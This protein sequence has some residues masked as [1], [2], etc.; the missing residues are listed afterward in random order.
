MNERR[1][2]VQLINYWKN[3]KIDSPLPVIESMDSHLLSNYWFNSMVLFS[4]KD[5]PNNNFHIEYIG[6]EITSLIKNNIIGKNESNF[7]PINKIKNNFNHIVQKASIIV[8]QGEFIDSDFNTHKYR[9]CLLP[10]GQSK[11]NITHFVMYLSY[12]H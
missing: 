4:N 2:T 12:L 11:N 1:H 5:F 9:S 3:L 8:D 6:K 7:E 10:F